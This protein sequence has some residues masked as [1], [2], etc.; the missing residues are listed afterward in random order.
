MSC[1]V[2]RRASGDFFREGGATINDIKELGK[3][4]RFNSETGKKAA[5]K[6][7]QVRR[8]K[9]KRVADF[10][11]TMNE[12]LTS[13]R[14]TINKREYDYTAAMCIKMIQ[15]A[16]GAGGDPPDVS[17]FKAVVDLSERHNNKA[18][19]TDDDNILKWIDAMTKGQDDDSAADF[20]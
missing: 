11:E 15:K 5:E 2:W 12:L 14:V 7:A 20:D 8:E 13:G 3:A 1:T 19:D 9:A 17:A 10:G 4:T 18:A 6:S 16:I